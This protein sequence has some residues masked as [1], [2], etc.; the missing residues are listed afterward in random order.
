MN[1]QPPQYTPLGRKKI[2]DAF[3][4]CKPHLRTSDLKWV[5]E[6][7]SKATSSYI[8]HALS[9]MRAI[10]ITDRAQDLVDGS[11]L[12]KQVI[13]HRLAG[14][15]SLNDW[16]VEYGINVFAVADTDARMQATRHA[17]LDSL[18]EEFSH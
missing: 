9:D 13:D 7:D 4:A 16:I 2:H 18:I 12:A 10:A 6:G 8:C 3:V 14:H 17:W 15:E 1:K 5:G 11:R